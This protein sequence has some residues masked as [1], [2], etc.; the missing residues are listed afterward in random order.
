MHHQGKL[1]DSR[2]MMQNEI[3]RVDQGCDYRQTEQLDKVCVWQWEDGVWEM[4]VDLQRELKFLQEI[5]TTS[6]TPE[7]V[8]LKKANRQAILVE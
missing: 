4:W 2:G 1:G 8:L 5:T 7:I 6:Q 3:L